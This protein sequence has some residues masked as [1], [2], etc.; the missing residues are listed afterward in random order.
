MW[1]DL[2]NNKYFF[3]RLITF[4]LSLSYSYMYVGRL[5]LHLLVLE[6]EKQQHFLSILPFDSMPLY[7]F[8]SSFSISM[9]ACF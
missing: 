8:Y 4:H 5:C 6:K 7:Q 9:I 1:F 3:I 2:A